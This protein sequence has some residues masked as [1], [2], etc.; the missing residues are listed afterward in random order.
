MPT[1]LFNVFVGNKTTIKRKQ[2]N[3]NQEIAGEK[4]RSISSHYDMEADAQQRNS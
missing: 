4:R 1:E 2:I 3:M